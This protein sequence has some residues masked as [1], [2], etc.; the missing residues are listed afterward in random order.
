MPRVAYEKLHGGQRNKTRTGLY[1]HKRIKVFQ[2]TKKINFHNFLPDPAW[3]A[4]VYKILTRSDRCIPM[5][6]NNK[7]SR[8]TALIQ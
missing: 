2:Q 1:H 6:T 8:K 4:A 7:L 5:R 3:R